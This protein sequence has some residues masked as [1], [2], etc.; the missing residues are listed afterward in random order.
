MLPGGGMSIRRKCD[1]VRVLESGVVGSLDYKIIVADD[2]GG[3]FAWLKVNHYSYGGDEST[4]NFYIQR[5][6]FFT[7]MKIDPKQMKRA[8]DGTYLGEVTPTRFAFNSEICIYPLKITQ[9][10][11]KD[12][13][14]ALFYVAAPEQMDMPGDWSWMHSYRPMYLMYMLGCSADPD[15][16]KEAQMH[17][18]WLTIKRRQDP[19]FE[20]T[21]LEWARQL[22]AGEM[23]VL[24][25]PLKNFGQMGTGDLP[26]GAKVVSLNSFLEKVESC[27]SEAIQTAPRLCQTRAVADGRSVPAGKR[28]DCR[29][30][31]EERR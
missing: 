19:R 26:P 3:L 24:E 12:K 2:A 16:Q 23:S 14:D 25:D 9:L 17:D 7:V 18:R 15:Q 11:V 27:L 6:W 20:T 21:K 10:V 31:R 1:S 28:D 22:G 8:P 29:I 5:K 13:T 30:R 4:L